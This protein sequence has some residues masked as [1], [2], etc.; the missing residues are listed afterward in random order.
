MATPTSADQPRGLWYSLQLLPKSVWLPLLAMS[1]LSFGV[2]FVNEWSVNRVRADGERVK[3]LMA[4]QNGLVKLRAQLVDAETGQRGYLLTRDPEYLEPYRAA[5]ETLPH[6]AGDVRLSLTDEPAL[7][8]ALTQLDA[9]RGRKIAEIGA[10]VVM[11]EQGERSQ[12]LALLR[13]GEGKRLLDAFRASADELIGRVDREIIATRNRQGANVALS[14]FASGLLGLLTLLLLVLV[15]RLFFRQSVRR[16]DLRLAEVDRRRQLEAEVAARTAELSDLSTHLQTVLED[17]RAH[18]A[19]DLHDELGG[20]LTAAKMDL[21]WLEGR[22]TTAPVE[23]QAKLA[24]IGNALTEAMDLKRRVVENLRPALLD[25]FGLPTALQAYFDETC[26]KAGLNCRTRIPEVFDQVPV[27]VAI[28]LFRVGQESLTNIIRHAQA[29]NVE[30]DLDI[31][32]DVYLIRI[33][34]DGLGMDLSRQ[35]ASHGVTGMRHRVSALGGQFELASN[36]G[37]GTVIT[38]RVPRKHP[39]DASIEHAQEG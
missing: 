28:G 39:E 14:R 36:P 9:L 6:T 33:S 38:I 2:F 30:M 1:L 34:D 31:D 32:D 35:R 10:T 18:L 5:L 4:A 12:A 21:S 26:R 37:K 16:E 19:R 8:A 3:D 27:D 25:H 11:A 23:Y 17:E 24:E 15:V 7:Q 29:T 13:S 22:S 20:L